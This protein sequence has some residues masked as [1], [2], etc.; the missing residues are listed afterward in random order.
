MINCAEYG[1]A[2]FLLAL[3]E[4]KDEQIFEEVKSLS[5]IFKENNDYVIILDS[6]AVMLEEKLSLIDSSLKDCD[7]Y[8]KNFVKMLCEK[9]SVFQFEDCVKAYSKEYDRFDSSDNIILWQLTAD[10]G[11]VSDIVDEIVNIEQEDLVYSV[12]Y[13]KQ[14]LIIAL[15]LFVIDVIIRK[16]S[17]KDIKNIF[18]KTS[19]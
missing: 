9:H 12:Y 3:E 7:E 15:I 10:S 17:W 5:K 14:L 19:I 18:R 8:V 2:L 13:N 1:K 16:L 6:P 11:I 4:N